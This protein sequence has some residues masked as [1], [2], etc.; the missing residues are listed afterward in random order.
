MPTLCDQHHCDH[1]SSAGPCH[2]VATPS[3]LHAHN[4]LLCSPHDP[5]QQCT[6]AHDN[7]CSACH[8][9]MHVVRVHAHVVMLLV[10]TIARCCG[11][12]SVHKCESQRFRYLRSHLNSLL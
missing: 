12:P 2:G 10:H 5:Q 6:H 3:L 7:V 8:V 1:L 11:A 9:H 4:T